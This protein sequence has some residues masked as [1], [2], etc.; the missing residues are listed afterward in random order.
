MQ[1]KNGALQY[2]AHKPWL[3]LS[4]SWIH[5][6]TQSWSIRQC[7]HWGLW[8]LRVPSP[9][10]K[11]FM[12]PTGHPDP[13]ERGISFCQDK[14]SIPLIPSPCWGWCATGV[15]PRTN[16]PASQPL[17][18]FLLWCAFH[19]KT[20]SSK[21]S[22][23]KLLAQMR[24]C[25]NRFST[26]FCL[27]GKSLPTYHGKSFLSHFKPEKMQPKDHRKGKIQSIAVFNKAIPASVR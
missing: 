12:P 7:P 1:K 18:H 27:K 26:E 8:L 21:L 10:S 17:G 25:C 15:S 19:H 3:Q 24:H 20:C 23:T 13:K 14:S 11:A 6:L 9:Y 5:N 22:I 2:A 16:Q 4:P